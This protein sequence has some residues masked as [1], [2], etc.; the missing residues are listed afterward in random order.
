MHNSL[1]GPALLEPIPTHQATSIQLICFSHA[2]GSAALY[3]PWVKLLAP[4]IQLVV[5]QLPGRANR[6][7]ETPYEAMSALVTDLL[8]AMQPLLNKPFAFF[9]HSMGTKVAYEL[10][11]AL[12]QQCNAKPVHFFAAASAAPFHPRKRPDIHA[13]DNSE[14]IAAIKKLGGTPS[15]VLDNAELMELCL[16][17]LRADFK[18]VET[19]L[20][21][22]R[23][24]VDCDLSLLGGVMDHTVTPSELADWNK[25]FSRAE[26]PQWFP[27]D[28]F[29]I[30]Q[31]ASAIIKT[32]HH[33]LLPHGQSLNVPEPLSGYIHSA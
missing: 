28:H 26:K 11:L 12:Q 23:A 32:I 9:G 13:L 25:V 27:G 8:E 6:L 29:F 2:G 21:S 14:F 33:K 10:A 22:S 4:G 20:N 15:A 31:Q 16:P 1:Q 17:T 30:N 5:C 18:L 3:R 7:F 24:K 19:Y